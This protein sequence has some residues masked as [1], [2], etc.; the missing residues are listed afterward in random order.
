MSHDPD[1]RKRHEGLK[2]INWEWIEGVED[3][4]VWDYDKDW[5]YNIPKVTETIVKFGFFPSNTDVLAN[6]D[7]KQKKLKKEYGEKLVSEIQDAID[8]IILK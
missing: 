7:Q 1:F 2:D 5:D 3:W 8:K 4:E 6:Y